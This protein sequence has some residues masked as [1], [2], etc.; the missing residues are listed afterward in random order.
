M[1][2]WS[3]DLPC[4]VSLGMSNPQCHKLFLMLELKSKT[5]L[6]LFLKIFTKK[7][8]LLVTFKH[9]SN[10]F[11]KLRRHIHIQLS[12]RTILFCLVHNSMAIMWNI[13]KLDSFNRLVSLTDYLRVYLVGITLAPP[14]YISFRLL[15]CLS[16]PRKWLIS[17]V[18]S[19]S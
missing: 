15:C 2:L 6:S 5:F 10:L 9:N 12:E 3:T 19:V 13:Y 4:N 16:T 7:I 14:I 8:C 18:Q 11:P 1:N 17:Q